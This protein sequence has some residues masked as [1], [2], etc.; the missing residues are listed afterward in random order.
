MVEQ[1]RQRYQS[2]REQIE[3]ACVRAGRSPEHVRVIAVTKTHPLETVQA[4]IDAGI[5]DI[6]E[7]K[8]QEL[9]DKAPRVQGRPTLH[10]IGHLQT[11][12][13]AKAVR[14]AS[15]IQSVDSRRLLEKIAAQCERFDK[16][17]HILIQVNASGEQSKYGC[18]P[19][20]AVALC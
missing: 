14:L 7:N 1:I 9:A 18:A 20:E 15:W 6:G 5:R 3:A 19:E 13:V 2:I 17:I 12:K 4:V 11:N 10:M 16:E 8:V